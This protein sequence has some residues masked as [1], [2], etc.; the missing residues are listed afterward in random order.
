MGRG[1]NL[2]QDNEICPDRQ[3]RFDLTGTRHSKPA[4][5]VPSLE[6]RP[7]DLAAEGANLSHGHRKPRQQT[8]ALGGIGFFTVERS[9]K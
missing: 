2:E 9:L 4:A 1:K 8:I 7:E 6:D 5:M 3:D